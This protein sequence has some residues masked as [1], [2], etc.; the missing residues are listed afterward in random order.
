MTERYEYD[1]PG[2]SLSARLGESYGVGEYVTVRFC[3]DVDKL[4]PLVR[5]VR[6]QLRLMEAAA[7]VKD[8]A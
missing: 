7:S 2:L 5:L 6:E 3:G 8:R 1:A 4:G